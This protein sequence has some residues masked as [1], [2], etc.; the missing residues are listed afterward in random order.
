MT[1]DDI[2]HAVN[3][4]IESRYGEVGGDL[5]DTGSVAGLVSAALARLPD[6][7]CDHNFKAQHDGANTW[8]CTNCPKKTKS[9]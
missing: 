7:I 2:I 8:K 5:M 9:S 3:V 4:E 6:P 1:H